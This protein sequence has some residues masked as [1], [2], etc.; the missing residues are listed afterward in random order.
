MI[1]LSTWERGR[2]KKVALRKLRWTT[3]G[4]INIWGCIAANNVKTLRGGG[5]G[6]ISP[7]GWLLWGGYFFQ[8]LHFIASFGRS[9]LE[10]S[11]WP[12]ARCNDIFCWR[13]PV[14]LLS[15]AGEVA[16]ATVWPERTASDTWI[17]VQ[18][19]FSYFMSLYPFRMKFTESNKKSDRNPFIYEAVAFSHDI[20]GIQ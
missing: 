16:S 2:G 5:A 9:V 17:R 10:T 20:I 1:Y 4:L 3:R 18:E 11:P 6:F 13:R 8:K 15:A 12:V 7:T 14:C 19:Q